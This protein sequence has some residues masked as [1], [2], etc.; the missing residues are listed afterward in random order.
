[1]ADPEGRPDAD[2]ERQRL[3]AI[4]HAGSPM[5]G[6]LG[7]ETIGEL[8]ALVGRHG[9]DGSSRVLDLGC[10]PA[11]LL[12]RIC[13]STGASGAGIDA[14]PFALTEARRRLAG[15]PARD[16][17]DLRRADATALVARGDQDL[18]LCIG[19]GWETGGW[20]ALAAWAS[21]FVAPGGLMLLGEG[22]WR[23]DP[24]PD[25]LVRLGLRAEEYFASSDVP[26][27]VA[28]SGAPVIWSRRATADEWVA[29]ADG[30]RAAMRAFARDHPA[31]P[32]T[33]ALRE[34]AEAGWVDYEILHGLLDFVIVLAT[35]GARPAE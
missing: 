28:A 9:I 32:V 25:A 1:V 33:A 23:V 3:S 16:R 14:S 26:S 6:P 24:P 27:A 19:P 10:G 22:A 4:A 31:D 35:S 7:V 29:Y 34:R 2:T 17:V 15:S 13:E 18:V 12:R 30:Y 11:E 21:G 5:W 8:T 20:S